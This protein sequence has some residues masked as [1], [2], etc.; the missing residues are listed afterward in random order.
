M[1]SQDTRRLLSAVSM[2]T[3]ALNDTEKDRW[4]GALASKL[5]GETG[6]DIRYNQRE[7]RAGA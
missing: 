1:I 5:Y 6:P 4:L 2:G 7:G 3:L